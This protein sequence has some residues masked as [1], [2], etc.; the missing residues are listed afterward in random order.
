MSNNV[1]FGK[2][3][4]RRLSKNTPGIDT[5]RNRTE[6]MATHLQKDA[7]ADQE[8]KL[9]TTWVWVYNERVVLGYVTLAMYS[10]DRR[11]ILKGQDHVAGTFPYSAIPALL[12]GQLATHEEYEG[13]GIGR[14]MVSWA[15]K[16]A[17]DI[18]KKV[19]CRM[20]ALHPHE[21]AI[22]WYEKLMFKLITRENRQ[23]IMYFKLDP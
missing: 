6:S 12:I 4:V 5:F 7:L 16:M 19:G 18:S 20:V 10:I 8:Q 15:I 14:R 13:K 11:D 23:A 2:V 17:A 9:G 22:G 1:D 21:D 3:N